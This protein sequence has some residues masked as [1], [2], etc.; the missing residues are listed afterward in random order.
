MNTKSGLK[1]SEIEC[2]PKCGLVT[3]AW[4]EA[5]DKEIDVYALSLGLCACVEACCLCPF[6]CCLVG[7]CHWIGCI[8]LFDLPFGP[9][10][11]FGCE[12][13]YCAS[14]LIFELV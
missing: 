10:Y 3:C 2:W 9:D 1:F 11:P 13:C 8:W 7:L 14:M 6:C 5:D 12:N 4:C